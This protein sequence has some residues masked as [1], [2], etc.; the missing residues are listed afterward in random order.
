MLRKKVQSPV[1]IP[2]SCSLFLEPALWRFKPFMAKTS[3]ETKDFLHQWNAAVLDVTKNKDVLG[4]VGQRI[5]NGID[6]SPNFL[7]KCVS[8]S[9]TC[10]M[11]SWALHYA[12]RFTESLR[13]LSQKQQNIDSVKFVDYGSGLSPVAI[14][15]KNEYN[16]SDSYCI[17][18]SPQI[19]ELYLSAADKMGLKKPEFIEWSDVANMAKS[20]KLNTIIGMGVFPYMSIEEQL[21]HFQIIYKNIPNF[22]IEIKYNSNPT[23]QK[24]NCFTL[25]NLQ[26][27]KLTIENVDSLETTVFRNSMR[28]LSVFRKTLPQER[29]FIENCRSLF[30]S[31]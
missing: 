31:R 9:L 28:Y 21:K 30:L 11:P 16:I 22:L 8:T 25:E 18:T 20:N 13:F 14:I 29:K 23:K 7:K 3:K 26:K 2:L 4:T 24:E 19:I 6:M 5:V 15:A 12:I 27:I 1:D 10:D 17:E